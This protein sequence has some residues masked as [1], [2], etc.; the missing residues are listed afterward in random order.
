MRPCRI[1][2]AP[3]WPERSRRAAPCKVEPR[4]AGC[5]RCGVFGGKADTA[6]GTTFN[7]VKG[8]DW[9]S[10]R[11]ARIVNMSF[12][13]PPDPRLHDTLLR[14]ARKGMV[15]IAAAGNAGPNSAPLYPGAHPTCLALP[16]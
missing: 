13:G 2:M 6:Q 9:A 4:R 5:S 8:L 7:I 10:E 14:A 12:A 3:A 16:R 15:L 1:P 11:G